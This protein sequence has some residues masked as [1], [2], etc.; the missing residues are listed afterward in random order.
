MK[1]LSREPL[2]GGSLEIA[3]ETDGLYHVFWCGRPVGHAST[4]M[5]AA[6]VSM[7]L[8]TPLREEGREGP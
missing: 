2:G 1:V 4:L 7:L 5:G 8:R 3:W 6:F